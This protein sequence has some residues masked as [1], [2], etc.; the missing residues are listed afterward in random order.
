MFDI[1]YIIELTIVATQI[2]KDKVWNE[3][4]NKRPLNFA[5]SF[6]KCMELAR[7]SDIQQYC[8]IMYNTHGV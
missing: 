3:L 1:A 2:E 4:L 5:N 6:Y 8:Y 7:L